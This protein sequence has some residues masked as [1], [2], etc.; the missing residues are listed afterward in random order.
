MTAISCLNFVFQLPNPFSMRIAV[1]EKLR[2]DK[3]LWAIRLFK[4][5][6]LASDA[7]E[8]GKVKFKGDSIK[9]SKQVHIG[10]E[11]V[12]KT[13]SRRWHIQVTNLLDHRVQHSEAIKSYL[14]ITPADEIERLQFQAASFNTG[15]RL[16]KQGRPTKKQRRDIE[17]FLE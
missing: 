6:A 12:V 5:R 16:S 15:K 7:C 9:A 3:Y 4:T 11:F 1:K 10:D 13:E 17:G 14:D 8:K 2:V